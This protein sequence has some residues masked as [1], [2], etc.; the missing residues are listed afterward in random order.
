MGA[1]NRQDMLAFLEREVPVHTLDSDIVDFLETVPP[2]NRCIRRD[3]TTGTLSWWIP[4]ASET[5]GFH[6]SNTGIQTAKKLQKKKSSVA[7]QRDIE[8]SKVVANTIKADGQ[9][10]ME[11]QFLQSEQDVPMVSICIQVVCVCMCVL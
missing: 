10:G 7:D 3:P 1:H 11:D 4:E 6:E 2:E 5:R 8:S 9:K